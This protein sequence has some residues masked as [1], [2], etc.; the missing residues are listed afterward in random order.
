M[1]AQTFAGRVFVSLAMMA[2]LVVVAMPLT[3][4]GG[5]FESSWD[6]RTLVLIGER[7]R[8]QQN[9]AWPRDGGCVLLVWGD[10]WG[11]RPAGMRAAICSA[12]EIWAKC[13]TL[14]SSVGRPESI[15]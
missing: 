6:A 8:G 1:P 3:I 14:T 15:W 13:L 5:T 9:W 11:V 7:V 4:V 10:G 2:G 12:Y